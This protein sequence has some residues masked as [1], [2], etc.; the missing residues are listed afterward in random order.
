MTPSPSRGTIC[1]LVEGAKSI[2][3]S[4]V[5]NLHAKGGEG[6]SRMEYFHCDGTGHMRCIVCNQFLSPRDAILG[7]D[8]WV[9]GPMHR[10]HADNQELRE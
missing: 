9:E 4:I 2:M 3:E 7:A 8:G 1:I 6:E 5:A 10:E